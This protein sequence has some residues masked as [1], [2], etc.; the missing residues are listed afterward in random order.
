MHSPWEYLSN[1][2]QYV[3]IW[4]PLCW[5]IVFTSFS[6][7]VNVSTDALFWPWHHQQQ[8]RQPQNWILPFQGTWLTSQS[9]CCMCRWQGSSG[10]TLGHLD[11][12][13]NFC[14]NF[15]IKCILCIF[16]KTGL[17][18]VNNS[19]GNPNTDSPH[20]RGPNWPLSHITACAG[21]GIALDAWF[22][23]WMHFRI[24]H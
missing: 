23:I 15:T 10:C 22:G 7:Y 1:D 19:A 4:S 6:G 5:E 12:L 14:I 18:I 17:G 21:G 8:C 20:P 9:H 24:L 11:A 2:I 13:P 16:F 3:M